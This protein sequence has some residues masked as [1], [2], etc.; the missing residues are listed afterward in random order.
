MWSFDPLHKTV[1]EQTSSE[2]GASPD[3][4]ILKNISRNKWAPHKLDKVL[5]RQL[6]AKV[7]KRNRNTNELE[8]LKIMQSAIEWLI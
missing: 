1:N 6:Y 7:T 5:S 8:S 2:A 4:A 3:P